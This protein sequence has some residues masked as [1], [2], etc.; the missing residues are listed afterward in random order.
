MSTVYYYKTHIVYT[1]GHDGSLIAWNFETGYRKH[2]LHEDDPTCTSEKYLE[3]G[4]SVDQLLI[5]ENR[6]N[7]KLV[8]MSAD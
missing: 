3:D 2:S 4:K 6:K 1:G 7:P 8:S 5:L